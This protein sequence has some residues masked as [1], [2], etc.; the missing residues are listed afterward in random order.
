M[1][2][3]KAERL[4][5]LATTRPRSYVLTANQVAALLTAADFILDNGGPEEEV[6]EHL[7]NAVKVLE[8]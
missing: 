4:A 2:M 3:S 8:G 5:L 7:R 1:T 6:L